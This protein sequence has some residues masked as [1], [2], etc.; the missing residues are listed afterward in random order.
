MTDAER[1]LGHAEHT[2]ETS[3]ENVNRIVDALLVAKE[4]GELHFLVTSW[5]PNVAFMTACV[6]E[7]RRRGVEV[8]DVNEITKALS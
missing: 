7:L 6:T 8:T 1:I 5:F 4:R 2:Y 3:P